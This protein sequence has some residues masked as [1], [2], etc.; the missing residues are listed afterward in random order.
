MES[1][2]VIREEQVDLVML[3][4]P[5]LANPHWPV[6]AARELGHESPF[7]L[8]QKD[9]RWWLENFQ[10]HAPSIGWPEVRDKSSAAAKERGLRRNR[11]VNQVNGP[12]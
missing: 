3:G 8:V 2:R 10:S 12:E 1:Q 6:W 5:A 7:S 4:R 9:W 11:Q